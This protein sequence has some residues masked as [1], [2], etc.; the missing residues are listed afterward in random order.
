MSHTH[1][2]ELVGHPSD[3][4]HHSA[5]LL[6][7]PENEIANVSDTGPQ[8]HGKEEEGLNI[9]RFLIIGV[10]IGKIRGLSGGWILGVA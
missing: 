1:G 10:L 4:Q 3:A 5:A 2:D 7:L 8:Q 6:L 9:L